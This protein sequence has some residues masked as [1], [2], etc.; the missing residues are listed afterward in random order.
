MNDVNEA[1]KKIKMLNLRKIKR[2]ED[3]NMIDTHSI[4]METTKIM[5]DHFIVLSED[6]VNPAKD[7]EIS[8][9]DSNVIIACIGIITKQIK[10]MTTLLQ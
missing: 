9:Y 10:M 5:L 6:I 8:L 7:A 2:I 4:I 3:L 1:E